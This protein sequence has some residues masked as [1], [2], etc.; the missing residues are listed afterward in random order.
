MANNLFTFLAS[1]LSASFTNL[2]CASFGLTNTVT[3]TMTNGV[4]TNATVQV[5]N[6]TPANPNG[7]AAGATAQNQA[8]NQNLPP[9]A[10]SGPGGALARHGQNPG[11]IAVQP[12]LVSPDPGCDSCGGQRAEA[13][14]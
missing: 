10:K 4:V 8:T 2:N 13:V 3:L 5:F 14:A 12:P 7:G 9:V 1:R 6:Q 11:Q